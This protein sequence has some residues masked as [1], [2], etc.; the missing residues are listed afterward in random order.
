MQSHNLT[1]I[2]KFQMKVFIRSRLLE[3]PFISVNKLYDAV[4]IF[5]NK[6]Y[7]Y[8]KFILGFVPSYSSLQTS[9]YRRKAE[10]LPNGDF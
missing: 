10:A 2:I 9:L 7:S 4:M 1:T 3:N 5:M 6:N 8:D